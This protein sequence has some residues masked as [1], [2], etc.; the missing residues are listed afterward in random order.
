MCCSKAEPLLATLAKQDKIPSVRTSAINQLGKY[1]KGDYKALYL[2]AVKDSSY[3]VSGS[4]LQALEKVDKASALSIAKQL[5]KQPSGMTLKRALTNI[6]LK[7]GDESMAD[8]ILRDFEGREVMRKYAAATNLSVYLSSISNIEKIKKGV[9]ALVSFRNE[10]PEAYRQRSI[11]L[12][13][14]YYI[15]PVL[16]SN[17][18]ALKQQP[19]N[20]KLQEL[21]TYIRSQ[22]PS[23]FKWQDAED[24]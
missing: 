9:E 5:A 15:G 11:P 24:E 10:V 13:N 1:A 17:E 18:A 2:S 22:L 14:N 23:G 3:N 7:S 12:I 20:K 16:A 4:A 19:D 8:S 21:V 6:I